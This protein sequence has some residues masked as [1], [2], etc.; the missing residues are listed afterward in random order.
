M[1]EISRFEYVERDGFSLS[2]IDAG[3]RRGISKVARREAW[4]RVVTW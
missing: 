2:A 1:S 4:K 3:K